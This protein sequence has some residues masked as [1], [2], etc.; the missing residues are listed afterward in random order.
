MTTQSDA[1]RRGLRFSKRIVV[2]AGTPVLTHMDGNIALGR[3]GSLVEQIAELRREGRDV[4]LVTSGAIGTGSNRIVKNQTLASN[5]RESLENGIQRAN[6]SA[7][8]AVGQSLMMSLYETLFNKYN[9]S[10]AQVLV[11][12]S[13]ISDPATIA[14]VGETTD[15]LLQFGIVPI[16][17]EN[18]AVTSRSEPVF[19]EDSLEV[20]WDNDALASKLAVELRADLMVVLTDIDGLYTMTSSSIAERVPLYTR[21]MQLARS[22]IPDAGKQ[23]LGDENRGDFE[24][25]TRMSEMGLK[26]LVASAV[27]AT[28]NGVRAVV[29]TTGHH[30]R[31]LLQ[32]CCA[33]FAP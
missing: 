6:Q 3:I 20:K 2:K 4:F 8:A 17:N 10:C 33:L 7:A 13:D 12:E 18:D 25:R 23:S 5:M 9:L 21:G 11:T 29:V 31:A 19:D 15:E 32:V 1:T 22:E 27:D 16:I 24:G 26:A 14:Q 30:P 28:A